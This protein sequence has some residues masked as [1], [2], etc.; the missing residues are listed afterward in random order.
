[1]KW[2]TEQLPALL[3]ETSRNKYRF[4]GVATLDGNLKFST[5]T[6]TNITDREYFKLASQG[7]SN[8]SDLLV[9]REDNVITIVFATPIYNDNNKIIGVLMA[10]IDGTALSAITNEV[11]FE[12]SGYAYLIND[13]GDIIAHPNENFVLEQRNFIEEAVNDKNF[14]E[15]ARVQKR[16]INREKGFDRYNFQGRYIYMGFAPLKRA[17]W[18]VAVAAPYNEV[19]SGLKGLQVGI[20]IAGIIFIILG[21]GIAFYVGRQISVPINALTKV[22]EKQANLD[23]RFDEKSKAVKYINRKDEIGIMT[24]S[25]KIMEDN[26][27]EMIMST[28]ESSQQV[29]SSSEELTATSQQSSMSA[30]EVART[31]EEIANGASEQAKDTEKAVSNITELGKLIEYDQKNLEELNDSVS[32]VTRLKEEGVR[33]MKHLVEKTKSNRQAS[34]EINEVIIN[35][36]DS[37]EKIYQASQMIKSIADQTNL[38]ALNAAIEAARAGEAGRGF[39]VVADEIRKLA[40]QSDKFTEE[41]SSIINDLKSKTESA[42]VTMQGMNT[43]V[44]EQAESVKDTESKFEGIA[45]AIEKTKAVIHILNESGRLMENKKDDII[46]VIGNLSAISEENA[47]GTEEASASVEEQTAAMGQ[48]A[49]ASEGLA[50]LAEEM[51]QSISKFKY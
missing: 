19:M 20:G 30:D 41:I 14:Q 6:E 47:A 21:F 13:K 46:S 35:A 11:T 42:V 31:I 40:E 7:H 39:A 25:I 43:I 3:N 22:V 44:K 9:S 29:A 45:V 32:E 51:N 26:I 4:M 8:V 37:A 23:F 50:K 10:A 2:E 18:S 27:R 12:E 24:R 34:Q 28:A 16:M 33:N 15:L 49:N 38:L 36:N 17:N 1:M 5:G 48:I